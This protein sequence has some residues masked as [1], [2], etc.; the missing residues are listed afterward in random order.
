M[1]FDWTDERCD[2]LRRMHGEGL[3]GGAIA[4][5]LGVSRN[6]A[7][8]KIHRLGLYRGDAERAR[9]RGWRKSPRTKRVRGA[10][11]GIASK[12]VS[13]RRKGQNFVATAIRHRKAAEDPGMEQSPDV[14]DQ[15]IPLEQRRTLM[16]LTEDTCRWPVGDGPSM[17][18]CGATPTEGFSYCGPH[19]RRAFAGVPDRRRSFVAV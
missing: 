15:A 10:D 9:L 6:A 5:A 13:R 18:F 4:D 11:G 8:G 19:C 2:E 14:F 7:I 16:Q 1:S 12:V 3:S 17:F